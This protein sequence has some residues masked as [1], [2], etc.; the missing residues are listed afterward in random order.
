[1]TMVTM[2]GEYPYHPTAF[3]LWEPGFQPGSFVGC[4]LVG[5]KSG[6]CPSESKPF[7]VIAW[8]C[9]FAV[10][11]YKVPNKFVYYSN[12]TWVLPHEMY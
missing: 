8:G 12:L 1:M 3:I 5:Q 7:W 2:V 6:S 10:P 9:R 11:D 4:R